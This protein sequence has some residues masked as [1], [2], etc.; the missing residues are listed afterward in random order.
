MKI[1]L[2]G[3]PEELRIFLGENFN[4]NGLNVT[5]NTVEETPSVLKEIQDRN[6]LQPMGNMETVL[7]LLKDVK[8]PGVNLENFKYDSDRD[9]GYFGRLSSDDFISYVSLSKKVRFSKGTIMPDKGWLVFYY[10][11]EIVYIPQHPIRYGISW[12]D[13]ESDGLVFGKDIKIGKQ[14]YNISLPTGAKA[15]PVDDIRWQNAG[16]D[17]ELEID[18]GYGSI[19]NE[20]IYRVHKDIPGITD[21]GENC[22]GGP[23]YGENWDELTDE[24][25]NVNWNKCS[26]GTA[27]WCQ[28]TSSHDS[29]AR[30]YRGYFRLAISNRGTSS[31]SNVNRG[32]R[33]MLKVKID[34]REA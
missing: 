3:T 25:L 7:E 15:N 24:E 13:L 23:Q 27:T 33:A 9:T 26:V 19:W 16:A 31:N 6:I 5:I 32:W 11:G 29:T 2:I 18:L 14:T 20:L 34:S 28:E 8:L 30:V 21:K 22:S 17:E 12:D 4:A 10:R 1:E